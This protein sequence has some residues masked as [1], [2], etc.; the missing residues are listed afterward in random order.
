[1][2]L[3]VAIILTGLLALV[4]G[5]WLPWWSIAIASLLIGLLIPQRAGRA[6]LAGFLG[7][8]LLWAIYAFIKDSRND[9]LLSAKIAEVLPLGGNSFLLIL[10][11]AFVGGIVGGFGGMT[12]SFL[13]SSR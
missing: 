8:F 12:G 4:A 10:V 5:L 3:F 6:F 2:K 11:T 7:I 13:R 1:M 9:G